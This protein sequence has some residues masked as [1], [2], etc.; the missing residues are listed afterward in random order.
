[1]LNVIDDY[2]RECLASIVDTSLSGR[3]AIR[4]PTK[5]WQ[6][7]GMFPAGRARPPVPAMIAFIEGHRDANGVG[8][9]RRVLPI[10]G[11][12][13]PPFPKAEKMSMTRDYG[14]R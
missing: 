11:Q 3:R 12:F 9:T 14:P 13:R 8:P 1:M 6:G 10:A 4:K 5:S 7:I 2:S